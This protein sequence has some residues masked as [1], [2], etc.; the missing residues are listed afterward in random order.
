MRAL[1]RRA[2]EQGEVK[3][4]PAVDI[5]YRFATT[6]LE[7]LDRHPLPAREEADRLG[8]LCLVQVANGVQIGPRGESARFPPVTSSSRS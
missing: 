1:L 6:R 3:A 5:D 4:G 2:L 7:H 8:G